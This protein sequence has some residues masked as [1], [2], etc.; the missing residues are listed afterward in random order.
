MIR[1]GIDDE[2]EGSLAVDFDR[3]DDATDVVVG[4]RGREQ[5]VFNVGGG[6]R[7]DSLRVAAAQASGRH[8][9][10]LWRG[11]GGVGSQQ[12]NGK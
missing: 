12:G 11:R 4:S 9:D 10:G 5:G 7:A 2:T 1:A 3:H 6:R 8:G